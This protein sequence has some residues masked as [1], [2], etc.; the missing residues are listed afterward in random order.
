MKP[1]RCV[2][3]KDLLRG[4]QRFHQSSREVV[5]QWGHKNRWC[6]GPSKTPGAYSRP[7]SRKPHHYRYYASPTGDSV[8]G[9]EGGR[10]Q[11]KY[12]KPTAQVPWSRLNVKLEQTTCEECLAIVAI[13]VEA[14]LQAALKR[15]GR[16]RAEVI[17]QAR[18][19]L[20]MNGIRKVV[21]A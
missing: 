6:D 21:G 11:G 15:S 9:L 12:A 18:G 4:Q 7:R 5:D 8:C 2:K 20:T 10:T 19:R 16:D 3:C 13:N 1:R 14:Q 17:E